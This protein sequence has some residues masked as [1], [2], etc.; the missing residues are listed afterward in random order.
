MDYIIK[1]EF[2]SGVEQKYKS[3]IGA[4]LK[5]RYEEKGFMNRLANGKLYVDFKVHC[6]EIVKKLEQNK[7][8]IIN[9][10]E[11]EEKP[12][13]IRNFIA[14]KYENKEIIV[15][16]GFDILYEFFIWV[17]TNGS[18]LIKN[19]QMYNDKLSQLDLDLIDKIHKGDY[20]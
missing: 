9:I 1:Y 16:K 5:R 15:R 14:K 4:I 13:S 2:P 19:A 17:K 10:E 3:N 7:A 6:D 18:T 12:E 11:V 20:S 8:K